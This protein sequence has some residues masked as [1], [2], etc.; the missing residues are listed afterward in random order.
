MNCN[1]RLDWEFEILSKY[2]HVSNQWNSVGSKELKRVNCKIERHSKGK[3]ELRVWMNTWW[4]K[5]AMGGRQSL[6]PGLAP[7]H[8][9]ASCR[10]RAGPCSRRA[11]RHCCG[12]EAR[13]S[14]READGVPLLNPCYNLWTN[15]LP[16]VAL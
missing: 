13:A 12:R 5:C 4:W 3:P 6:P 14:S 9:T 8:R 10:R 11:G 2:Y 16:K 7:P 15:Y 1:K